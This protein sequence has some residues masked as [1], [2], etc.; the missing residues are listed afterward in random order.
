MGFDKELYLILHTFT[1]T[2]LPSVVLR[3][4]LGRVNV[5]GASLHAAC[6]A[7][8]QIMSY[9]NRPIFPESCVDAFLDD[10]VTYDTM[11]RIAGSF[12][13]IAQTFKVVADHYG[14]TLDH[15]GWTHIVLV[16]DDDTTSVCWFGAKPFG[17]VFGNNENY[18]FTWLR[19]GSEQTD[20][21]LDDILQ[22]I[23]LRTRGLSYHVL[24]VNCVKNAIG[25]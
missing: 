24:S 25:V 10:S 18:T 1:F 4:F 11:V 9:W 14:W 22:Q 15:Y 16:S 13:S 2:F 12:D 23:R 3:V 19:I 21:Q 8:G 17:D 7:V 5:I 6:T 20:E